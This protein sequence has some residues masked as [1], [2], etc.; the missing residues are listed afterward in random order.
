MC[1]VPPRA[2][3]PS[4]PRVSNRTSRHDSRHT[5]RTAA[6]HHG[7]QCP[8]QL[9]PSSRTNHSFEKAGHL[10]ELRL[11]RIG[12]SSWSSPTRGAYQAG[13]HVRRTIPCSSQQ[14]ERC[15]L[16]RIYFEIRADNSEAGSKSRFTTSFEGC[17]IIREARRNTSRRT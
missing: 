8:K 9:N 17:G 7:A 6:D 13:H 1:N 4:S 16:L 3:H 11:A 10:Y 12:D 2:H 14:R 15:F 5:Q